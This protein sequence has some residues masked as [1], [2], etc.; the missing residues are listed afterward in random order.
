VAANDLGAELLD[1]RSIHTKSA[2]QFHHRAIFYPCKAYPFRT[3]PEPS[4]STATLD[5]FL[6]PRARVET[7]GAGPAGEEKYCISP[8]EVLAEATVSIEGAVRR[9]VDGLADRDVPAVDE[10][11]L[12]HGV[13]VARRQVVGSFVVVVVVVGRRASRR[14][15]EGV[16]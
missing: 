8:R 10:L 16:V 1:V 11:E 14:A 9:V 3:T 7:A 5:A 15:G 12:G 2:S 6:T 4:F 13:G